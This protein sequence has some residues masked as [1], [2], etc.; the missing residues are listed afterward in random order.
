MDSQK[1]QSDARHSEKLERSLR[2]T[3]ESPCTDT[4]GFRE[5]TTKNAAIV[6]HYASFV[7]SSDMVSP[8]DQEDFEDWM[9]LVAPRRDKK[10]G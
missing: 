9:R 7:F 6:T 2:G 1:S 3:A 5:W 4:D 10:H 8:D